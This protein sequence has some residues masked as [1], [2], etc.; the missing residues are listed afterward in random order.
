MMGWDTFIYLMIASVVIS[1]ALAPKAQNPT[2]T[3]FEDIDFPQAD[4]GTACIVI[5]G[6][7]YIPD[8]MVLSVGDYRT[9][10]IEASGAK[11]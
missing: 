5:W 8:W 7:R 1:V 2:P 10:P 3:A 11:K 6:D 9:D 4:E